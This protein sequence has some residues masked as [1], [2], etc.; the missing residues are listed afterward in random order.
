MEM[1]YNWSFFSNLFDIHL[2]LKETSTVVESDREVKFKSKPLVHFYNDEVSLERSRLPDLRFQSLNIETKIQD[3]VTHFMEGD[4]FLGLLIGPTGCGK[5]HEMLNRAKLDF[6]VFIDAKLHQATNEPV[7]VSL[8]CLKQMFEAIV[9]TWG[10]KNQNLAELR[11]IAYAFVL[12]RMLFL[13]YLK[14]KYTA[15]TATQFLIH[16]VINS[17]VIRTCFLS[18]SSL[19]ILDLNHIRNKL[20]FRKI[21]FC[22]DEAHSLIAHLEN[23]IISSME[24]VHQQ[25]NDVNEIAK[26]G[27]LSV[28]LFAIKDGSFSRKVIF[29]GTS[30]KL[31]NIDNF[32]TFES[33]PVSPVVLNQFTAWNYQ[34]ALKYVSFYVDIPQSYFENVLTDYYRPRILENFIYDLFCIGKN[35]SESP[36]TQRARIEN[37]RNLFNIIDIIDESYKAVIHRFTRICIEP[38][39]QSIRNYCQIEIMLKLL[40]SSM[41]TSNNVPINCQLDEIQ[42]Y[43]FTETIGSIYLIPGVDGYSF[44]EGYII[45][46]FLALFQTE[47]LQFNLSS[48]LNL[49]K[50]IIGL[51]GKKTTAKGTPFEAVVLA[52]LMK[53]N[54]PS[55]SQL[56][57]IFDVKTVFKTDHLFLP[58]AECKLDDEN[59]ISDRPLNLFLR[60]SN[61]FRPDILAFLTEEVCISFGIKIYSSKISSIVHGDNLESTDP[62]LFFLKS[63]N[64]T[65]I[66]KRHQWE[67]SLKEIPIKFSARFLIELPESNVSTKNVVLIENNQETVIITINKNNMRQLLSEEVSC[68]VDFITKTNEK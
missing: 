42:Q 64:P 1:D 7:D 49:L 33:K 29:A 51:E 21:L 61:Q 26:R 24:G 18:L 43:F 44:F 60:P 55:L 13:K 66:K 50:N 35:D 39:A 52:D 25:N 58:K 54:S 34:T 31:R 22:V 30:S 4:D 16:Q 10:K 28:I 15:L 41:M 56:L 23:M 9:N 59:I 38:L 5:T 20:N 48:S 32:G 53:L 2:P 27:T 47:L 14:E 46:S 6:T 67:K 63:D 65:N 68:L 3:Y 57:S 17:Q 40:L 45:N 12:S 11:R 8:T 37:R 19:S 36:K 62:N